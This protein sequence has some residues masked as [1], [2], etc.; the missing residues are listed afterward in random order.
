[1]KSRSHSRLWILIVLL[2][3]FSACTQRE[4][5]PECPESHFG[6][7]PGGMQENCAP[8]NKAMRKK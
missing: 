3:F 7:Q 4:K 2:G 8:C 5:D 1:M 6:P